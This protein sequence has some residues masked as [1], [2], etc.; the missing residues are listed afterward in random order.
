MNLL[1]IPII[2]RLYPSIVRR[3]FIFFRR[4][5]FTFKIQNY[6]F[7]LDIRESIERKAYFEKSYE[8]LRMNFLIKK[9]KE[10]KSEIF[11]DI[12]AYIGFYSIIM[13]KTFTKIYSFEP[14]KRNFKILEQNIFKNNL[15]H[16]I[17]TYN[18]GLGNKIENL[19][20]GSNRKGKLLQ[21]SGFAIK[22]SGSEKISINIGDK[23]LKISNKII[24]IKI[25]VEGFEFN[26]LRGIRQI[27]SNNKCLLQIEIWDKNYNDICTFLNNLKYNKINS[28]DG[29]T[30]F[31]N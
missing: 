29:D 20:G 28:I 31:Q 22:K 8:K 11:I 18:L 27:L 23:L 14:Q 9:S 1:Q 6:F 4:I 5:K 7:D 10:M 30:F 26:V 21:S 17:I 3:I 16:K 25:D 15:N 13:S 2:K 24:T 19:Y 12:G